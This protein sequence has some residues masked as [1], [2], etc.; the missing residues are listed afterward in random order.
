MTHKIVQI[1]KPFIDSFGY[2]L[3][4]AFG[5]APTSELS[6]IIHY[7]YHLWMVPYE[8]VWR[9]AAACACIVRHTKRALHS[10]I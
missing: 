7:G 8:Y 5:P 1:L 2:E 4:S 9:D 6:L 10:S 3:M